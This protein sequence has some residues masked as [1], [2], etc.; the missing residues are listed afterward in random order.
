MFVKW[1]M[2][3]SS[4]LIKWAQF[5]YCCH[6]I[7]RFQLC[8]TRIPRMSRGREEAKIGRQGNRINYQVCQVLYVTGILHLFLHLFL[9]HNPLSLTS[10]P[11]C[12]LA[13]RNLG[14]TSCPS[15]GKKHPVKGEQA[16]KKASRFVLWKVENSRMIPGFLW[17]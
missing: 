8:W 5:S 11:F 16:K 4:S 7:D 1:M 17:V 6:W 12:S 10:N 2:T 3:R 14:K 9:T 13:N 15:G